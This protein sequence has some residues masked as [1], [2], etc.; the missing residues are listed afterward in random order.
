[1]RS[2]RKGIGVALFVGT[3]DWLLAL[4]RG[5]PHEL[6]PAGDWPRST[7]VRKFTIDYVKCTG[8]QK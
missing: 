1:M 5:G 8:D 2:L 6:V 3:L 7:T 4:P